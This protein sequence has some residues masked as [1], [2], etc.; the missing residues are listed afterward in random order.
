MACRTFA[1]R[2]LTCGYVSVELTR[3]ELVAPCLQTESG[4]LA[5][6]AES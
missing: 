2:P 3:L 5:D 1:I 6:Q 4:P